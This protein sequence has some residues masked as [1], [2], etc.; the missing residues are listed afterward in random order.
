MFLFAVKP[1]ENSTV[2]LAYEEQVENY[3][4]YNKSVLVVKQ[5]GAK[6]I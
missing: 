2:V 3:D 4:K 1:N 5:P 6:T